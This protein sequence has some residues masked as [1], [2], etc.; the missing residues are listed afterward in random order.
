M[1]VFRAT[2]CQLVLIHSLKQRRQQAVSKNKS[3]TLLNQ[4]CLAVMPTPYK[5]LTHNCLP[6]DLPPC[7]SNRGSWNS[8]FLLARHRAHPFTPV[9]YWLYTGPFLELSTPTDTVALSYAPHPPP[10]PPQLW[11]AKLPPTV[12]HKRHTLP[13][14]LLQ[15]PWD[16]GSTFLRNV[17]AI[18]H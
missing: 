16:G 18:N 3:L 9:H 1:Y 5:F 8:Q 10:S 12:A 4:L 7:P 2:V 17:A 14:Q 15:H 13:P 11:F 6:A